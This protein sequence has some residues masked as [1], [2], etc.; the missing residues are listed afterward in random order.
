MN[1]LQE[2]FQELA[3]AMA[4]DIMVYRLCKDR[5]DYDPATER[6]MTDMLEEYRTKAGVPATEA[7]INV[8][9]RK[10]GM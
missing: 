9:L 10:M 7:E 8:I 2:F 6:Q 5:S 4:N 3:H 1:S